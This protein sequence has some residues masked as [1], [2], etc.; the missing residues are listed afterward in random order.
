[1]SADFEHASDKHPLTL[2]DLGMTFTLTKPARKT[3]P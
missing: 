1:M 3:F 2:L